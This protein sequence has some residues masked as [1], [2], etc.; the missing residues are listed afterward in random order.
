[1]YDFLT[2]CIPTYNRA[3]KLKKS[4]D[5]LVPIVKKFNINI[6]VSDNCSTDNTEDIVNSYNTK[7]FRISYYKND[8]NIGAEANFKKALSLSNSDYSWLLG[9]DDIILSKEINKILNILKEKS[10]NL[11][12]VNT[13]NQVSKSLLDFEY[14]D[15]EKLLIDLGWHTTFISALIFGKKFLNSIDLDR[16]KKS[17][18]IHF[19]AIFDGLENYQNINVYYYSSVSVVTIKSDL[20]Y[21]SWYKN[22]I[23]IFSD[24]WLNA[25]MSLPV[26]FSYDSKNSAAR[27]L[28]KNA[29]ITS[30]TSLSLLRSL[31][32]INIYTIFKYRKSLFMLSKRKFIFIMILTILP[33]S[34]LS[35]FPILYKS[36]ANK[37][38]NVTYKD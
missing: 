24:S 7:A 36:Y 22:F 26:G 13:K 3:S 12:I 34:F 35:F 33:K 5:V 17:P 38:L 21:P 4:L 9:D 6:L 2:L 37:K 31:G 11:M 14:S 10:P 27:A 25:V 19:G 30:F 1:M 15:K 18:F 23:E 16:F 28:W 29:R 20:G 32:Y 8:S